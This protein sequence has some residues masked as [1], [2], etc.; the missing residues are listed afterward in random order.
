MA[1]S[2][3]TVPD[4]LLEIAE[5]VADHLA[6]HGYTVRVE[7]KSIEYPMTPTLHCKRQSTTL[8]IEVASKPPMDRLRDWSSYGKSCSGDTRVS[9]CMPDSVSLTASEQA[10]LRD[11]GVGLLA[12]GSSVTEMFAA[13]DL[14]ITMELPLL[15]KESKPVQ[16]ALGQAYE[17]IGRGN[18]REGFEDACVS[19]ETEARKYLTK[20]IKSGRIR[21][22]GKK[23]R[24]KSLSERGI[25]RMPMGVLKDNFLAIDTPN[26]SDDRIASALKRVNPDRIRVA[27]K[28]R[29]PSAERTLRRN[30]PRLMWVI[31]AAL[32]E[33][34]AG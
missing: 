10:H 30:A 26:V 31:V 8:F 33:M 23:G 14:A 15:A 12:V 16:R 17:Q 11:L 3:L 4:E 22:L 1:R 7:K 24:A 2:F 13:P 5:R 20:H 19:L 27:H 18:W 21:V 6:S 25:E 29:S 32:R 9:L 34:L 28:R